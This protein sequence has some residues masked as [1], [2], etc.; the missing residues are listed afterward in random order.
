VVI[1]TVDFGAVYPILSG[2]SRAIGSGR[3]G[4]MGIDIAIDEL[5]ATGW[6]A[7][8]S[9]GCEL[10]GAGR[11]VPTVDRV[12]QEFARAG[13]GLMIHHAQLFDC[14]RA[15]W[16]TSSGDPA[17]AVVGSTEHEA[18]IYALAQLRRQGV[19]VA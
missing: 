10:D 17:G 14:Y 4:G 2:C 18:A 12:T 9:A 1:Q 19:G 16:Q 13:Y 6:S 7:L 8:D 15:V 5:Y 3:S 11:W